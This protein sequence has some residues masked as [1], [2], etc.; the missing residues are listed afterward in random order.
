MHLNTH[1]QSIIVCVYLP[2]QIYDTLYTHIQGQTWSCRSSQSAEHSNLGF[3]FSFLLSQKIPSASPSMFCSAPSKA[4]HEPGRVSLSMETKWYKLTTTILEHGALATWTISLSNAAVSESA[5]RIK[6][7][8]LLWSLRSVTC[9]MRVSINQTSLQLY[10]VVCTYQ[11]QVLAVIAIVTWVIKIQCPMQTNPHVQSH[12]NHGFFGFLSLASTTNAGLIYAFQSTTILTNQ[13]VREMT[14]LLVKHTEGVCSCSTAQPHLKQLT[15]N[16]FLLRL[17][18][19][20]SR[21]LEKAAPTNYIR[22]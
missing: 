13:L 12:R 6:R 20:Q 14:S 2:I 15:Q 10:S 17:W 22:L 8:L 21:Q 11:L 4:L 7:W 1:I 19:R 18:S 9:F 3:R 16:S 5:T